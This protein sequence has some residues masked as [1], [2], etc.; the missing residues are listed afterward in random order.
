MNKPIRTEKEADQEL[1]EAIHQYEERRPGLGSDFLAAIDDVLKRVSRFPES[2]APV[3]KVPGHLPVRRVS[4]KRFPYHIVYLVTPEAIRVLA[5]AHHRRRPF[6][7]L[8]RT[9]ALR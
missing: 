3:P 8:P 6:Y 4:L 2:G 7:W 9:S 5:F 1:E